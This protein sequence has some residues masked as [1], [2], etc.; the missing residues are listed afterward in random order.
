MRFELDI[1]GALFWVL[2]FSALG[3]LA[4][5]GLAIRHIRNAVM[6]FNEKL[7]MLNRLDSLTSRSARVGSELSLGTDRARSK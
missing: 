3:V 7:A 5:Y 1:A 4:G 6:H 2:V